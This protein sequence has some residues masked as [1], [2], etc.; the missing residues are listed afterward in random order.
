MLKLLY[1]DPATGSYII[2]GLMAGVL[3]IVFFFKNIRFKI[4]S[5]LGLIKNTQDE[6]ENDATTVDQQDSKNENKH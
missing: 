2:Q 4:L 5:A 6:D 3:G 1:L